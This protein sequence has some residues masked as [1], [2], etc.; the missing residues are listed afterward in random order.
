ML[1][2]T[3]HASALSLAIEKQVVLDSV[4]GR[5]AHFAP[6]ARDHQQRGN[7]RGKSEK[8]PVMQRQWHRGNDEVWQQHIAGPRTGPYP[9]LGLDLCQCEAG[10]DRGAVLAVLVLRVDEEMWE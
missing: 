9:Y 1:L 5:R 7:T 6:G 10:H 3:H 8:L 4:S 2:N